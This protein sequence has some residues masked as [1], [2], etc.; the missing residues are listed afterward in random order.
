MALISVSS[1]FPED[2][3]KFSLGK[4]NVARQTF[5]LHSEKRKKKLGTTMMGVGRTTFHQLQRKKRKKT[6]KR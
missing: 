1:C 3:L 2:M 6:S 4:A 5:D